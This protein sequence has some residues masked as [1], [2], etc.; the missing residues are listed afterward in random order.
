MD[1]KFIGLIIIII[2]A[3][4]TVSGC[5]GNDN[6]QQ[7]NNFSS[8]EPGENSVSGNDSSSNNINN[9]KNDRDPEPNEEPEPPADD[10]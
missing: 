5:I 1:K 7:V 2:L 4:V 8:Q 9:N 10:L 3:V 6:S